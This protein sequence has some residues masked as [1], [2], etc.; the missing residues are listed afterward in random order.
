VSAPGENRT[1]FAPRAWIPDSWVE[2]PPLSRSLMKI[3]RDSLVADLAHPN[4]MQGP[5]LLKSA[6]LPPLIINTT[7]VQLVL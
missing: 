6:S 2:I 5:N 4:N 1:F 7:Y 3:R